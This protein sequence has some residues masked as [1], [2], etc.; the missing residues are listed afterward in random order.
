[1]QTY[2]KLKGRGTVILSMGCLLIF[3]T[4]AF[5]VD[6]GSNPFDITLAT[7]SDKMHLYK[8]GILRYVFG[9]FMDSM[10]ISVHVKFDKLLRMW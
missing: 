6:F 8:F 4:M 5:G 7:A 2:Y 10:K 3:V 1:M 9:V